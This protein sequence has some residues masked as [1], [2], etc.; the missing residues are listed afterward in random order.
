MINHIKNKKGD[1]PITILVIG[2]I[3]VCILTLY[4]FSFSLRLQHKNFAGPGL[5]ETIYSI[6]E[7]LWLDKT[8]NF[9]QY[10]DYGN[11]EF[12]KEGKV[13]VSI[14]R[15]NKI[16]NGNY[17]ASQGFFTKKDNVVVE[18]RYDYNGDY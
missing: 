17:S 8:K 3:A 6:Q 7:E 16:I 18:I 12:N 10:G 5:I 9:G 13:A 2:V 4:S 15:R 14:D 1:I 11:F